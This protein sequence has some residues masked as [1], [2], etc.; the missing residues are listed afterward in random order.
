MFGLLFVFAFEAVVEFVVMTVFIVVF[1][2]VV[3][4]VVFVVFGVPFAGIPISN[5]IVLIVASIV[6]DPF[7]IP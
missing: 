1:V 3:G 6:V 4:L 7:K 2:G 5:L